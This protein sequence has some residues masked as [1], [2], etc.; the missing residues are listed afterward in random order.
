VSDATILDKGA[1][2]EII[3]GAL[4]T[5]NLS[6]PANAQLDVS[7][8]ATIFGADSALDSLGLVALL[9]DIEEALNDRGVAITL[10]DARAMSQTSSPF[11]A[12]TPLVDYIAGL[13]SGSTE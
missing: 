4:R 3:L 10:T 5:A 12:V 11:R 1:I 13:V 8:T 2:E 9:I 7:P 6:R